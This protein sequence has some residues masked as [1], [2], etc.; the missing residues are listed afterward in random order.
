MISR[1]ITVTLLNVATMIWYV[2]VASKYWIEPSLADVP[3]A[4]G[5]AF[6]GWF[7]TAVPI[8]A[9]CAVLNWLWVAFECF[10]PMQKSPRWLGVTILVVPL[11]WA[12]ALY[13]DF[14]HH[15]M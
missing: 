3:G 10:L 4:S 13:V 7:A 11:L 12:V 8:V 15:G 2:H 9:W 1:C 5:G 14:S 6:V